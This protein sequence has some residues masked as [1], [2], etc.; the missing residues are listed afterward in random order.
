MLTAPGVLFFVTRFG[1]TSLRR[2]AFNEK[3]DSGAW[4]FLDNSV[5][6][7][8]ARLV[9]KYSGGGSILSAGC[10]PGALLTKLEPAAYRKFYGFDISLSAIAKA[11]RLHYPKTQFDVSDIQTFQC[12]ASFDLI[13]FEESLYYVNVLW[14]RRVL[15]RYTKML[16]PNGSIIVTVAHPNRFKDILRHIGSHYEVIERGPFESGEGV[17]IVFRPI[18]A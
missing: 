13:L 18:A 2:L 17:F 5:N 3:Y 1:G 14:R 12:A 16:K 10:G 7:Q 8:I 11:R 15:R 6:P 4:A 9:E